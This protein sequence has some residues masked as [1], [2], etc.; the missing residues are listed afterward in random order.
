MSFAVKITHPFNSLGQWGIVRRLSTTKQQTISTRQIISLLCL[1]ERSA[2]VRVTSSTCYN[3]PFPHC[4]GFVGRGN[5]SH[6]SCTSPL[7]S[8]NSSNS[9]DRNVWNRKSY[10]LFEIIFIIS[11]NRKPSLLRKKIRLYCK[12][13]QTNQILMKRSTCL[14]VKKQHVW[15]YFM[16]LLTLHCCFFV[17][18][19]K[20]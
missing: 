3:E 16:F 5:S 1:E 20:A 2:G 9:E 13:D 17:A 15:F 7:I 6:H 18:S 4:Y 8:S 19:D 10:F 11:F 12:R 14:H